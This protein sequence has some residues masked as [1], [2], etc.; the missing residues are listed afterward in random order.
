[1]VDNRKV[2]PFPKSMSLLSLSSSKLYNRRMASSRDNMHYS[3]QQEHAEF[4]HLV[5]AVQVL[6]YEELEWHVVEKPKV[7]ARTFQNYYDHDNKTKIDKSHSN[8]T[9]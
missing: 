3:S 1:M 4:D 9:G 5:P 8:K 6:D 7:P 2:A